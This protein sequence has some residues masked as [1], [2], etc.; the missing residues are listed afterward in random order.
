MVY[1]YT[2]RSV[3][4]STVIREASCCSIWQ[5]TKRSTIYRMRDWQIQSKWEVFIKWLSRLGNLCVRGSEEIIKETVSSRHKTDRHELTEI[6][7]VHTRPAQVQPR[8]NGHLLGKEKPV[9][10]NV[11]LGLS[12]TIQGSP[13]AQQWLDNTKQSPF[14]VGVHLLFVLLFFVLFTFSFS[15]L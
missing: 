12:T 8:Q 6:K 13:H 14:C 1:C 10:L 3:H 5:L 15:F 7:R 9:L 4:H 2:H 11:S